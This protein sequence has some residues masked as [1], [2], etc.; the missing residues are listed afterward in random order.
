MKRILVIIFFL[1]SFIAKSQI[2]LN[3]VLYHPL[4]YAD[5]NGSIAINITGGTG[6]LNYYWLNGTGTA[7][8]L[9]GL[10]AGVYTLIVTDVLGT[11]CKK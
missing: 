8:S 6:R 7:D 2:D 10:V 5:A 3:E 4:C 11:N 1:S 9:Y